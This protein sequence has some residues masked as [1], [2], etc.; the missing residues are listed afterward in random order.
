MLLL[1]SDLCPPP[2]MLAIIPPRG[3]LLAGGAGAGSVIFRFIYLAG[4]RRG[5]RRKSKDFGFSARGKGSG[6]YKQDSPAQEKRA[7]SEFN[8]KMGLY[9]ANKETKHIMVEDE[10]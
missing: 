10:N 6:A 4:L 2:N 8:N 3:L 7:R 9:S 5:G 1:S